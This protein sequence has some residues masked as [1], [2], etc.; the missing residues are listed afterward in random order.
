MK[1]NFLITEAIQVFV[2]MFHMRTRCLISRGCLGIYIYISDERCVGI[3]ILDERYI[4][5]VQ[6]K[7]I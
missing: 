5:E 7:T 1:I 6:M 2:D 3:Y 4:P